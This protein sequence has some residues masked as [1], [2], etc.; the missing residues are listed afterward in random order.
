MFFG[1]NTDEGDNPMKNPHIYNVEGTIGCH[2]VDN[3]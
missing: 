2:P 3:L 1:K